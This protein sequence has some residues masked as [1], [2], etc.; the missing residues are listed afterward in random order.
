MWEYVYDEDMERLFA[1]GTPEETLQAFV[2]LI[3][4]RKPAHNDNYTA[5]VIKAVEG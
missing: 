5:A 1:S 3:D 2:R 4:E